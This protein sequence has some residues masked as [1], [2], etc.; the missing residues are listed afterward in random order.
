[1]QLIKPRGYWTF[2]RCK[3]EALKYETRVAFKNTNPS[4]YG[5]AR[6]KGWINKVCC[7]MSRLR[8]INGCYTK[9]VCQHIALQAKSRTEFAKLNKAAY[10]VACTNGWL[11]KICAHLP[12]S[13]REK[14]GYWTHARCK[15]AAAKC[16]TRAEFIKK[17]RGA[18]D[19]AKR[20]NW[21]KEICKHFVPGHRASENN[22]FYLWLAVGAFF[23]G[24]QVYKFGVTSLGVDRSR[25]QIV[26]NASGFEHNLLVWA[27]V[28]NAKALEACVKTMG[29]S[30]QYTGFNGCTEFRALTDAEVHQIKTLAMSEFV[31]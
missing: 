20:N 26:A 31:L 25:I 16:A 18:H 29:A 6:K 21:L 5:A 15:E 4:A 30:P 11:D 9:S 23:N 22:C 28:A 24:L 7:H 8:R 17:F 3:E 2:E 14:A 27:P 19:A 10:M 13:K 12:E 1:M